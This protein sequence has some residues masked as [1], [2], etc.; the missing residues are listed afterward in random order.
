[1]SEVIIL[2]SDQVH[3]NCDISVFG[4]SADH[5]LKS[6]SVGSYSIPPRKGGAESSWFHPK[7]SCDEGEFWAFTRTNILTCEVID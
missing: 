1:M 4:I 3:L 2:N 5:S 6:V 7:K